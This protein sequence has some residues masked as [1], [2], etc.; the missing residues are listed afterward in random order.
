M[1]KEYLLYTLLSFLT[2]TT[3]F[4]VNAQKNYAEGYVLTVQGDTVKGFIDD[5]NW[6]KNPKAI[7]FKRDINSAQLV[8]YRPVQLQSFYIKPSNDYYISYIGK[9]DHSPIAIGKLIEVSADSDFLEKDHTMIDSV[10][11]NVL[12]TGAVSLYFYKDRDL[13]DHFFFQKGK[14]PISELIFQKYV[15]RLDNGQE[16]TRE[17]RQY[18]G[19]LK[20]IMNDCDKPDGTIAKATYTKQSLS[21]IVNDYNTCSSQSQSTYKKTTEKVRTTVGL[22]VGMSKTSF[23]HTIGDKT[24]YYPDA[25]SPVAGL[26]FDFILPRNRSAWS[27]YSDVFWK[28]YNIKAP[29]TSSNIFERT[30]KVSQ[31]KASILPR[32]TFPTRKIRPF[33]NAG[34]STSLFINAEGNILSNNYDDEKDFDTIA[35]GLQG[36]VGIT[37]K[38]FAFEI[39]YENSKSVFSGLYASTSEWNM[40]GLL[41]YRIK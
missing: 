7:R 16:Y 5:K 21:G 6:S 36:G 17:V 30:L 25:Y 10:F 18:R 11:V 40:S 13:K 29:V 31:L 9:V 19:Q 20:E 34:V 1:K 8:E 35:F 14:G 27:V 38:K 37:Y 24:I 3:V 22:L 32:Y 2:L 15:R 28:A 4:P 23:L 26:F 39:R 33:I 12:S 41:T